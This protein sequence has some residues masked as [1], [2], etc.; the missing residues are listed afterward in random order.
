MS[1]YLQRIVRAASQSSQ[2]IRPT[3]GSV[4]A[5]AEPAALPEFDETRDDLSQ[6]APRPPIDTTPQV[7]P[8]L[9]RP[10]R[11][12]T[13][14]QA[15]QV[16]DATIPRSTPAAADT[17]PAQRNPHGAFVT[18]LHPLDASK[19]A[20]A[21]ADWM[22]SAPRADPDNDP[23][24]APTRAT[25]TNDA[26][27]PLLDG[28]YA[29]PASFGTEQQHAGTLA[30]VVRAAR[31]QASLALPAAREADEVRIHIGRIEVTAVAAAPA[32]PAAPASRHKAPS[33]DDY[34][35]RRDGERS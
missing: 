19:P 5:P 24:P 15:D 33:L 1:G 30:A 23:T 31:A 7:L 32:R 35:K 16:A 11:S 29:R 18:D 22:P 4:F 10:L 26:Y 9:F 13:G 17:P 12:A 21:A 28:E 6:P 8:T 14:E 2:A 34:L 27:A 3:Q 20:T 25:P